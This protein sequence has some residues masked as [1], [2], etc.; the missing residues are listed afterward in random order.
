[1]PALPLSEEQLADAA[2]LKDLFRV[3]Q[4]TRKENNLPSSQEVAAAAIGFGQSALAQYL[5]GR[6]PL[7]VGAGIKFAQLLGVGLAEF[8]PALASEAE[9]VA[10]AVASTADD[11]ATAHLPDLH[12]VTGDD[13]HAPAMVAIRM[14]PEHVRAG[15]TGFETDHLFE[16]E[17]LLHVPRQWLEENDMFPD[18]LRAVKI[19]GQS[20]VPMMYPGDIAVVNIKDKSRVNGGVFA[21]NFK[22]ESVVKRLRYERREWYLTSENP[23]FPQEPCRPGDCDVIG[24]VVRFDPRNFKDRL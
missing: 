23:D 16:D 3:W 10:L 22:G 13:D 24:R 12:R 18:Q 15:I 20:M 5:N 2:R 14:V 8:S 21:L 4:H 7:N 9:M 6:I 19:K 11:E 1:M 17:G